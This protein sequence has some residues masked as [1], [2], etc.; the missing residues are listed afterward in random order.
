MQKDH[1]KRFLMKFLKHDRKFL[2][3]FKVGFLMKIQFV[4]NDLM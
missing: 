3:Y 4:N 1:K 2:F